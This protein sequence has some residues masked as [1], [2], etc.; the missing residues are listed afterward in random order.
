MD[1]EAGNSTEEAWK[2]NYAH[3]Q[4][5]AAWRGS[6][7]KIQTHVAEVGASSEYGTV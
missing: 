6:V 5:Q 7:N 4:K 2:G 3:P 1:R